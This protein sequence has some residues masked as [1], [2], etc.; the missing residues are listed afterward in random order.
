[1]DQTMIKD[2]V[3]GMRMTLAEAKHSSQYADTVYRFC[4]QA[5]KAKFDRA[6][7]KFVGRD[8]PG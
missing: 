4:S 1:M 2:P 7:Q 8:R 3:C 5:C 6:P